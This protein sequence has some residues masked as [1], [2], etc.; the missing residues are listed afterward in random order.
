M[1]EPLAV[2]LQVAQTNL[3]LYQQLARESWDAHQIALV[4][5]AYELAASRF[6]RLLRPN[7]KSFLA[8]LVGTASVTA[9][10]GGDATTVAVALLHAWRS[11]A[12]HRLRWRP[13]GL[14][15][16]FPRQLS[17]ALC[18]GIRNYELM[19][20][21][22]RDS[23]P[24]AEA[25]HAYSPA[26]QNS[27][28]IHLAN[29]YEELL[30]GPGEAVSGKQ[31]SADYIADLAMLADALGKPLLSAQLASLKS[32]EDL[33]SP[34]Y[35]LRSTWRRSYAPD[36]ESPRSVLRRWPEIRR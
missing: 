11:H 17:P 5:G 31:R 23:A 2:P 35:K 16:R 24:A 32:G 15:G 14:R 19:H 36:H 33:S 12:F 29:E 25:V 27:A 13:P 34:K 9:A 7:G 4:Q 1:P 22:L 21:T 18:E 10:H 28:L 6:A 8:H 26:E 20:S 3:Q 30:D